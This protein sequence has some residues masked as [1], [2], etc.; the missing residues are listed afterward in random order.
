MTRCDLIQGRRVGTV[1]QGEYS[2]GADLEWWLLSLSLPLCSLSKMPTHMQ[3]QAQIGAQPV[4]VS[5]MWS[6]GDIARFSQPF[7]HARQQNGIESLHFQLNWAA[8][9]CIDV[10]GIRRPVPSSPHFALNRYKLGM[11]SFAPCQL[12]S[13]TQSD[14]CLP[15][16]LF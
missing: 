4:R 14:W 15:G 9:S 8:D 1:I 10:G 7:S 5:R 11:K 13:S 2:D 16:T 3:T 12:Y 6:D